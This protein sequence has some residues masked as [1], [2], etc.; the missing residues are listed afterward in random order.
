MPGNLLGHKL[1]RYRI[2]IGNL[3]FAVRD[4]AT[5]KTKREQLSSC[6]PDRNFKTVY[7]IQKSEDAYA[8]FTLSPHSE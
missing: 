6:S 5:P 3:Y 4:E 7:K 2:A 8:V 1:S